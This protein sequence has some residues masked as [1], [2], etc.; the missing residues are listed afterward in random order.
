M[1]APLAGL[2]RLGGPRRP[3]LPQA[4][5]EEC[6]RISWRDRLTDPWYVLP[7]CAL[8]GAV[9]ALSLVIALHP[10]NNIGGDLGVA[11][12]ATPLA[13]PLATSGAPAGAA[14]RDD[15]R[16]AD[17]YRITAAAFAYYRER[18]AYPATADH[19]VEPLCAAGAGAACKLEPYLNPLPSDPGGVPGTGYWY[20]SDGSAFTLF[21]SMETSAAADPS[22]CPASRPAPLA[23]VPHLFC[24]NI[25]PPR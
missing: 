3:P 2:T 17:A 5:V 8:A 16:R 12:G 13:S 21:M 7:I 1:P 25:G 14:Q 18:H 11:G 9:L 6:V 20:Q 22:A 10:D 24:L 4:R 23:A 15:T 19:G